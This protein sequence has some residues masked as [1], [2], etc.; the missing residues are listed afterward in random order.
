MF[1]CE[2]QGRPAEFPF[3]EDQYCLI[4]NLG[5][6]TNTLKANNL[7]TTMALTDFPNVSLFILTYYYFS[8]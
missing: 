3:A 8:M 5:D 2:F 6:T 1:K 7:L 4:T